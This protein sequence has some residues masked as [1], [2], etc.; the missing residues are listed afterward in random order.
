MKT[1]FTLSLLFLSTFVHA[2][3]PAE[4]SYHL[5]KALYLEEVVVIEGTATTDLNIA[6]YTEAGPAVAVV[7]GE[8]DQAVYVYIEPSDL[9]AAIVRVTRNSGEVSVLR[10]EHT[11]DC[12]AITSILVKEGARALLCVTGE[13]A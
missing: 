3:T 4:I 5:S 2:A 6:A 11:L 7:I 8:T 9:G 1:L 13:G 10:S 12:D